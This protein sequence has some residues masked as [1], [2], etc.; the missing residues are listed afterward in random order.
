MW[1]FGL[2]VSQF[3]VK[4]CLG[5]QAVAVLIEDLGV[6]TARAPEALDSAVYGFKFGEFKAFSA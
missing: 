1:C 5:L 3:R 2:L 4:G 6:S